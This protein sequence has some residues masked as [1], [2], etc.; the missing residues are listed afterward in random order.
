MSDTSPARAFAALKKYVRPRQPHERC[1]LCGRDIPHEHQHLV[2]TATRALVCSCDPCALLFANQEAARYRA[3]PRAGL[4]LPG[5]QLTDEQW[6]NLQTPINLAFFLRTSPAGAVVAY[7]PSP[8]G[9]TTSDLP[10]EAWSALCRANPVLEELAPDVEALLVNRIRATRDYFRSPI[11][12]CYELV[13]LIR[14]GWRGISG[15]SEV[16]TEIDR[17]FA[18]LKERWDA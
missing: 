10:P 13:G 16:W 5:F 3:V 7:Y 12:T 1:E 4:V 8:A 6:E 17:F 9:A 2:N 11:D 18:R 14:S 15:G